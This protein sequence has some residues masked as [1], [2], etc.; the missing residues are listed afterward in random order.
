M[1]KNERQYRITKAQV[2]KFSASLSQLM[3]SPSGETHPMLRKAQED[4][5]HSQLEE[6]R[7]QLAEYDTLQS[8]QQIV[9][10]VASFNDLSRALI[11]ARIAAGLSQK[12][13][14]DRLGLKEQQIQQYEATE[15]SAASMARVREVIQALGVLVRED[16][17]LPSA[18]ISKNRL[19]QRLQSVGVSRD[20][21]LKRILS[22]LLAARLEAETASTRDTL[23]S[24][25]L[26]AASVVGHVFDLRPAA[27]F[28]SSPL[29]LN[30]SALGAARFK[31]P[32]QVDEQKMSAYTVYAHYLALLALQAT[33]HLEQ[34]AIPTD[35][36]V[37]RDAIVSR[38]GAV[39]FENAL[40]YIWSLGVA[41]L[42]LTDSGS[43]HG[44]C[45]RVGRR[46]VIVLKQQ[47]RYPARWL[48][49]GLH[50]LRHAGQEPLQEERTV[51][52]TEDI[53][54][55]RQDSEEEGE[56]R[57][58]AEDV[59]FGGRA[60]DVAQLCARKAGKRH[61]QDEQCGSA[62]GSERGRPSGCAGVLHRVQRLA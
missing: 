54:R 35:P 26:E 16:V 32:A 51:I 11:R 38:Y 52:E 13:L 12:Q 22:P 9:L 4:A 24:A 46:N 44:A 31:L 8:G 47:T 55:G 3:A 49:D 36:Y 6:L 53:L 23:G 50:E 15:Y 41:V 45:W 30:T 34:K 2:D 60:E 57:Y 43:F 27:I 37:V 17:F 61:G 5:L 20:L 21:V 33:P 39:T 48:N 7:S 42:P 58:F 62:G 40:R 25:A 56:A 1:I 59:I 19:F 18:D 10:D 29:R 28:D 14:A